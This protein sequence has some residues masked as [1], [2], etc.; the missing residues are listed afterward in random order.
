[1]KVWF[2]RILF[3]AVLVLIA[4]M[5]GNWLQPNRPKTLPLET[6][7]RIIWQEGDTLFLTNGNLDTAY[8]VYRDTPPVFYDDIIYNQSHFPPLW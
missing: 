6:L 4:V 3:F 1:M 2:Q 5:V 8:I 7:K